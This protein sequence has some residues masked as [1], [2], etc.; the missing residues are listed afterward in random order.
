VARDPRLLVG[1]WARIRRRRTERKAERE[2]E[3]RALAEQRRAGDEPL[4]EVDPLQEN[5]ILGPKP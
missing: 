1:L 3:R 2:A 5:T 4:H